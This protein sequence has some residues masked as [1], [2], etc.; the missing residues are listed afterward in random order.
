MRSP[1]GACTPRRGARGTARRR[2]R[3]GSCTGLVESLL[4]LTLGDDYPGE[5]AVKTMCKCTSFGHDDVRR[6]IVAQELKV[7]P[8][9]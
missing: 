9:R 1:A 7:D 6:E 8:A 4:A 3:C 5:R 2:P